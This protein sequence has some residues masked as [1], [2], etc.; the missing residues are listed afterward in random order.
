MRRQQQRCGGKLISDYAVF[1]ESGIWGT[2][3][4]VD[5]QLASRDPDECRDSKRYHHQ[6]QFEQQPIHRDE[7]LRLQSGSGQELQTGAVTVTDSAAPPTQVLSLTGTGTDPTGSVASSVVTCPTGGSATCYSLS[8]TCPNVTEDQATVKVEAPAGSP[9]GTILLGT[10]GGGNVFYDSESTYGPTV[11]TNLL[12]AGFTVAQ[13]AFTE[14]DNGWL[15]GPGG[16]RALACRYVSAAQW[17]YANVHVGGST[18]PFCLH[19]DSGGAAQISYGMAHFGLD[20]IVSMAEIASGPPMGRVDHG[21]LCD[22]PAVSTTPTTCPN[23]QPVKECYETSPSALLDAAYGNTACSSRDTSYAMTFLNDSVASPDANYS[24]PHTDLH[25]LFGGMDQS[26][27]VPLGLDYATQV[28][29][30]AAFACV[31]DAPHIIQNAS[32][33]ASKISDDLIEFCKLQ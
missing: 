20:S 25:F 13:V 16:P 18:A 22:Q 29:S 30:K 6:H 24:Y 19:G 10:A 28:T 1:C 12:N 9:V 5:R 27:A 2:D 14:S 33:G 11:V 21:C 26:S 15:Q 3:G 4:R 32:D 31:A 23:A 7:R 8:I 17:V